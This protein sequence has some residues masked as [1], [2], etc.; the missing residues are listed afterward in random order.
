MK[1]NIIGKHI[2]LTD[3]LKQHVEE[4]FNPIEKRFNHITSINVVLHIENVTQI[5]EATAH[6]NGNEIHASASSDDMYASIDE[7]AD[8]LMT[9]VTK[10]KEKI[11]DQHR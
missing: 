7:T 9:Q 3:A 8:K 11:I 2:D 6:V 4:K 1:L 5:V 10:L